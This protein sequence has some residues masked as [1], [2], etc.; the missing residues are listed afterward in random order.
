MLFL[1][2]QQI[3][4]MARISQEP[5]FDIIEYQIRQSVCFYV[6][7]VEH[8]K[9]LITFEGFVRLYSNI[10]HINYIHKLYVY[11]ILKKNSVYPIKIHISE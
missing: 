6:F 5:D 3:R 9:S 1:V 2:I 4:V 8:Q 11:N 7:Q 10:L